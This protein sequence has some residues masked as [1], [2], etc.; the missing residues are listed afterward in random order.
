MSG[1]SSGGRMGPPAGW[2]HDPSGQ[3]WLRWWDGFQWTSHTQPGPG[4]AASVPR[5]TGTPGGSPAPG[6]GRHRVVPQADIGSR[7]QG[8]GI[9]AA[10]R[11][12]RTKK[13]IGIGAAVLL[14]AAIGVAAIVGRLASSHMLDS[15]ASSASG[16][17]AAPQTTATA[18]PRASAAAPQTTATAPP[19][20]SA[21]APQTTATAPPRASAAAPQTT[22]T[23]PPRASAAAPQTTATAP[24]GL[25]QAGRL[26]V[27]CK[28]TGTRG[29]TSFTGTV[30]FWNP[31]SAPQSVSEVEIYWASNGILLSSDV[32][33]VGAEAEPGTGFTGYMSP[34]LSA[35]SCI[36][37]GWNP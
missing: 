29:T 34:P 19:R 21:A 20:A 3:P 37:Q 24:P 33:A 4:T 7:P 9:G 27:G 2:Y 15:S 25:T 32:T 23:A 10:L 8:S 28:L 14:I 17:G 11:L 36:V 22:A 6:P 5:S 30:T 12:S 1:D 16:S 35:T 13:S 26:D 18:P 31:G